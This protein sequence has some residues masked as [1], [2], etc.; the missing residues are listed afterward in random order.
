MARGQSSPVHVESR[1]TF[2]PGCYL[3]PGN[4]RAG[5]AR[6]PSYTG[7]FA[8]TNDFAA[9]TPADTQ[10]SFEDG[11]LRA[12]T[13]AG[14]VPSACAIRRA[15]T[16]IS[17]DF[18]SMACARSSMSGPT[19]PASSEDAIAG[20]RSSR[21]AAPRWARRVR[22]RTGRS[23]LGRP[24]RARLPRKMRAQRRHHELTRRRLLADYAEQESGGPRVVDEDPGMAGDRALLGRVALRDAPHPASSIRPF[25]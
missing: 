18:P 11:L 6:N 17:A 20:S 23:G 21:T 15:M 24:S 22:I 25:P 16:S 8:F 13:E 1:P 14:I 12:E 10:S 5:G 9:L 3:C 4:A 2:D 19:R 7:P